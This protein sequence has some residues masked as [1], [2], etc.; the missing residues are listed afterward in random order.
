M[1]T[2]EPIRKRRPPAGG[3]DLDDDEGQI[4]GIDGVRYVWTNGELVELGPVNDG[5]NRPPMD[6]ED[7]KALEE[8][9]RNPAGNPYR[10]GGA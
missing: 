1:T 6:P 5:L 8:G 2:D 7:V 3:F 4:L 10:E 9:E